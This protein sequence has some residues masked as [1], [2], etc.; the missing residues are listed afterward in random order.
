LPTTGKGTEPGARPENDT[1]TT[2]AVKVGG[3][4][5]KLKLDDSEEALI[6]LETPAGND[7]CNALNVPKNRSLID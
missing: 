3:G 6:S 1:C 5:A 7:R 4:S 2:V